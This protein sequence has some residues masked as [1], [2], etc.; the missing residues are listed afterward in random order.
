[1]PATVL[2][3]FFPANGVS[4]LSTIE[5]TSAP[6]RRISQLFS[7]KGMRALRRTLRTLN[8]VVA[9]SVATETQ[10]RIKADEDLSGK[11]TVETETLISR[12]TTAADVTD[13]TADLL[14]L[15]TKTYTASPVANLDGNP[16]GTR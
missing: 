13:I 5:T 2:G 14:T 10:T 11:R 6:R 12:A 3:G 4:T 1:M 8:G 9:G 16:L 15:S 7:D